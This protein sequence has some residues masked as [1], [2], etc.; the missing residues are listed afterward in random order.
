LLATV[1]RHR[2]PATRPRHPD[3]RLCDVCMPGPV[4][5][6]PASFPSW[7]AHEMRPASRPTSLPIL[8]CAEPAHSFFIL[9]ESE[10]YGVR[11]HTRWVVCG[12]VATW[13]APAGPLTRDA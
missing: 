6:R 4:R 1:T 5:Y 13:T 3:R 11:S 2:R 9:A 12:L 7:P 8:R 10:H